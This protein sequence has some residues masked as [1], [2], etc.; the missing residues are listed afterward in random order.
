M[1]PGVDPCQCNIP[2]K[3][4]HRHN[5][6]PMLGQRR[7]RWTNI[8]PALCRFLVFAGIPANT[9]WSA[10]NVL[11]LGQRR[12]RWTNNKTTFCQHLGPPCVCWDISQYEN[13]TLSLCWPYLAY[14][15]HRR[16]RRYDTNPRLGESFV[17]C[18][19][20]N[21]VNHVNCGVGYIGLAF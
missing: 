11:L 20:N 7:R 14:V 2:A 6:G 17:Y 10:N 21:C 9:R 18:L 1:Y 13:E 12:R 19:K 8:G 3:A 16:R 4:S 15:G 5:V